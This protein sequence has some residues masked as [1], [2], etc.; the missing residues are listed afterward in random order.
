HPML[1]P[2]AVARLAAVLVAQAIPLMLVAY[3]LFPRLPGALWGMHTADT[4]A[5]IGIPEQMQPGN[6]SALN[7]SDEIAFRAYF[8][9][10]PPANNALYWRV[11]VFWDSD[12]RIWQEGAALPTRNVY[13]AIGN[14]V[15]Y[16]LVVE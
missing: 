16:R 1:P 5:T 14:P 4:E 10:A 11:R 2:I 7:T 15:N 3:F 12:G 13:R 9:E 6:I 8:E